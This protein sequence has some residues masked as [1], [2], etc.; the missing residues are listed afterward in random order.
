MNK[1]VVCVAD[2]KIDVS[3]VIESLQ[4]NDFVT[5]DDLKRSIRSH[6]GDMEGFRD[7]LSKCS[8]A[9]HDL[10]EEYVSWVEDVIVRELIEK[11]LLEIV[12]QNAR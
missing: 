6:R 10:T 12:P 4:S 2:R 5:I 3:C 9:G 8:D 7:L 1:V 11:N